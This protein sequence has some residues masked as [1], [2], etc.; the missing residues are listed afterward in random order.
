MSQTQSQGQSQPQPPTPPTAQEILQ[1]L[2]R[3]Y[4]DRVRELNV[5]RDSLSKTQESVI[6]AQESAF[7]AFQLLSINKERYLVNLIGQ[8]QQQA[9][10]Y[11]QELSKAKALCATLLN[12]AKVVPAAQ[13]ATQL[14]SLPVANLPVADLPQATPPAVESRADNVQ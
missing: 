1:N 11:A 10:A 7:K 9:T 6:A 2:E 3:E 14:T 5:T 13:S 8:H 4:Q 12:Q